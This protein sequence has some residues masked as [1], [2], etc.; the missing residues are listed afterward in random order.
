MDVLWSEAWTVSPVTVD[1]EIFQAVNG[2]S[3][4]QALSIGLAVD[5]DVIFEGDH[6]HIEFQPK[7]PAWEY[8]RIVKEAGL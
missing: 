5:Y 7:I 2:I 3:R 4:G 8:D 6:F 1:Y